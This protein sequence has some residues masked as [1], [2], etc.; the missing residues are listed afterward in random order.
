MRS[1]PA[2][3]DATGI[4]HSRSTVPPVHRVISRQ[5]HGGR[6]LPVLLYVPVHLAEQRPHELRELV[7]GGR[8]SDAQDGLRRELRRR[9]F[10]FHAVSL[11]VSCPSEQ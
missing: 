11:P 9:E 10:Q 1:V 8:R 7:H 4:A 2:I 5:G 6:R 3:G